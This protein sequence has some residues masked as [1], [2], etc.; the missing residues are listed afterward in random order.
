MNLMRKVYLDMNVYN[1]PFDDQTQVRIRLET[2]AVFAILYM[3]RV[4]ESTGISFLVKKNSKVSDID[5]NGRRIC[6]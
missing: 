3:I 5:Y 2:I 4:Q 1:R 6:R